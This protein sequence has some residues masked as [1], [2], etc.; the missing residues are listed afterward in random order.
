MAVFFETSVFTRRV[1]KLLS[2]SEY[3]DLQRM[4]IVNPDVGDVIPGS[5]GLRKLRWA[6][7]GRGKRSG[8]R[9]I[10]YHLISR[11]QFYMLLI[12]GKNEQDDLSPEQLRM[13]KKAVEV[14][15]Q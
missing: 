12:Y 8:A 14:L 2:D 5:G 3:A 7:Q 11:N 15:W 13:L 10:Y 4:L 6:M 9:V 1:T